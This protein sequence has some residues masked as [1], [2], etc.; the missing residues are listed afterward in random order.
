MEDWEARGVT[1]HF[2]DL[3]VDMSSPAGRMVTSVMAVVAQWFS[4]QLSDRQKETA[5][6][7]KET[8]RA[9]NGK[10][11]LGF[12]LHNGQWA[13][14]HQ[15]RAVMAMIEK[16]RDQCGLTWKAIENRLETDL[17]A[18][19][20]RRTLGR[21]HPDRPWK[22]H[23]VRAAYLRWKEIQERERAEIEEEDRHAECSQ[24]EKNPPVA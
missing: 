5:A 9:V 1:I 4:D 23:K 2:A 18:H 13:P 6:W 3:G 15:E 22:K 21:G 20:K 8:N 7:L 11:L 17:A 24:D 12:K 16:L 10:K 14:D 19:N